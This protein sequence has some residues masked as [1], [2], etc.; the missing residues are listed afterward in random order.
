MNKRQKTIKERKKRVVIAAREVFKKG[1]E[2]SKMTEIAKKADIGVASLYRYYETK[3]EIALEVANA[4]WDEVLDAVKKI[5][6]QGSGYDHVKGLLEFYSGQEEKQ[7][8]FFRFLED[9]DNFVV[10]EKIPMAKMIAYEKHIGNMIQVFQNAI[11]QGQKDGSI[12]SNLDP[13]LVCGVINHTLTAMKQKQYLRAKVIS[14]D[15]P[16]RFQEEI[17]ILIE[18]FLT[19]LKE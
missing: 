13:E 9:F 18:I 15:S 7:R 8:Y 3:F 14:K 10:L 16:E 2:E 17:R 5:S 11:I 1:I 4:Y 19:Y 12:K 6:F